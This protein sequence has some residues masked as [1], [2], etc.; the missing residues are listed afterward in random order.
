MLSLSLL[1]MS[2]GAHAEASWD[3]PALMQMLAQSSGGEVRFREKKY[4]AVLNAPLESR[5]VL[6]YAAPDHLEKRTLTPKPENFIIDGDRLRVENPAKDLRREFELSRF[7]TLWAFVEG[8]RA[9]LAGDLPALR[10]FYAPELSGER[11]K[12]LLRL[13]P[14][15]KGM[16]RMVQEIRITGQNERVRAI[17]V[18]ERNGDH[19]TMTLEF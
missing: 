16:A 13:T 2:P 5:G 9:T 11:G 8:F 1:W 6:V 3:L 19:S 4:L 12:W 15:E 14:T 10:R 18:L 7:P 17:E